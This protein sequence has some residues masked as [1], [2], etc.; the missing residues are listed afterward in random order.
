MESYIL[1]EQLKRNNWYTNE[2]MVRDVIRK[3][4]FILARFIKTSHT[5]QNYIARLNLPAVCIKIIQNQKIL[6]YITE[7]FF[8]DL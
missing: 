7:G 3:R 6:P 4:L 8:V 5:L 2:S 1:L